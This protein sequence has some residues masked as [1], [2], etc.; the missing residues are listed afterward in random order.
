MACPLRCPLRVVAT[1]LVLWL[2]TGCAGRQLTTVD[3]LP[4]DI[5]LKASTGEVPFFRQKQYHCGPA[6]LAMVLAWTG[7]EVTPDQIAGR[8][9]TPSLRGSLQAAMVAGA[10]RSGRL[11]Y[12]IRGEKALYREIAAGHPVIV[13][14]NLGLS[15]YP[16]WH[17]AV[18]TGYDAPA[19]SIFLHS[20]ETAEKRMDMRR[21][22]RTW[23]RSDR[24][25]LLVLMPDRLPATAVEP[26]FVQAAV[27]LENAGQ[28]SA[29]LAAFRTALLEWP[30]NL[31]AL[32]G[33]GNNHYA[34]GNLQKAAAAFEKATRLHPG[35]ADAF[36][37]L[38]QVM[39]EMGR[40]G[41]AERAALKALALG[42]PNEGIYRQTLHQI[43]SG[44]ESR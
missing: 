17:Y 31:V 16:V 39:F 44:G 42:G 7:L 14:Q 20:G 36:N 6:T 38:A 1:V 22:D 24:W 13:L 33:L 43:Q 12:V 28:F 9:F 15:W 21:F 37:N 4:G 3:R 27:G 11:A 34:L 32:M 19:G 2:L 40:Y 30:G 18:V 35:S 23:A 8:V 26:D 41:A 25:G 10:R 29:A 5:P